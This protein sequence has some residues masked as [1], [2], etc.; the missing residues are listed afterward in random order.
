MPIEQCSRN[1]ESWPEP[2]IEHLVGR[3]GQP[4]GAQVQAMHLCDLCEGVEPGSTPPQT[5][6]KGR[7]WQSLPNG[8]LSKVCAFSAFVSVAAAFGLVLFCSR[9]GLCHPATIAVLSFSS[10]DYKH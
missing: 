7:Q 4:R 10:Q 8:G 5:S 6:F 3:Q 2:V 9:L 1:A